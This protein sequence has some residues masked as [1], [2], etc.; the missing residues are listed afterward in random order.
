VAPKNAYRSICALCKLVKLTTDQ[1]TMSLE[2]I[3]DFAAF[4]LNIINNFFKFHFSA[5]YNSPLEN[6]LI[7]GEEKSPAGSSSSEAASE[8]EER[9]TEETTTSTKKKMKKKK[10]PTTERTTSTSPVLAAE[11]KSVS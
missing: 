11:T 4:L 5:C 1:L 9:T 10:P 8:S 3:L 6:R 7:S 2:I